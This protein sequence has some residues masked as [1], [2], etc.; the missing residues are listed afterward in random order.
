MP[1]TPAPTAEAPSAAPERRLPFDRPVTPEE[2]DV[3]VLGGLEPVDLVPPYTPASRVPSAFADPAGAE[4]Q[5]QRD[6]GD[7]PEP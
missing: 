1:A 2:D 4:H 6:T 7:H 5:I 3:T